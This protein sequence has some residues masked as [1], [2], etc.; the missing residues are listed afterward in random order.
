MCFLFSS[1]AAAANDFFYIRGIA[2]AAVRACAGTIR[3]GAGWLAVAIDRDA[4]GWLVPF[5]L[6]LQL[7]HS[8]LQLLHSFTAKPVNSPCAYFVR[9]LCMCVHCH[10]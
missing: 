6:F 8:V 2:A 9:S 10:V 5:V 3:L 7:L 1:A 4:V